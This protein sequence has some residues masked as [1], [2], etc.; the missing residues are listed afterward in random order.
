MYFEEGT[1]TIKGLFW[2][3]CSEENDVKFTR[4]LSATNRECQKVV[5]YTFYKG[6]RTIKHG[7]DLCGMIGVSLKMLNNKLCGFLTRE[8]IYHWIAWRNLTW[9]YREDTRTFEI[10]YYHNKPLYDKFYEH[11][12]EGYV[13]NP[14]LSCPLLEEYGSYG[15]SF[16]DEETYAKMCSKKGCGH[17]RDVRKD[18][19]NRRCAKH[20][21]KCL[22]VEGIK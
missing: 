3:V 1:Y 6:E 12:D 2:V 8:G 22:S 18:G 11:I 16:W 13:R 5:K 10:C 14:M 20:I 4:E 17:I 19:K 7:R 15:L 9:E 21:K